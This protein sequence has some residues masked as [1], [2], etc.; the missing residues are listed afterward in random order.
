MMNWRSV[1]GGCSTFARKLEGNGRNIRELFGET[2]GVLVKVVIMGD[3]Y[4]REG[5]FFGVLGS[6]C[7]FS[8]LCIIMK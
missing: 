4:L 2:V 1:G 3:F 8:F 7:L 6:S 5:G